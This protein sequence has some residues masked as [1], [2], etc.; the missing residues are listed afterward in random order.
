MLTEGESTINWGNEFQS[1]NTL[2]LKKFDLV[3]EFAWCLNNFIVLPL[4]VV[5]EVDGVNNLKSI[6]H[7]ESGT[8]RSN[9]LCVNDI[10]RM[11]N[12]DTFK[13]SDTQKTCK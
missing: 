5:V 2:L 11:V 7:Q 8:S 10:L 9:H 3:S 6:L 4:V 1:L 13:H 12:S